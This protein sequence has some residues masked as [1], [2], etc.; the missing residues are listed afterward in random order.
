MSNKES[1]RDAGMCLGG[2]LG[3]FL[4][5]IL[6]FA[7]CAQ[8]ALEKIIRN[9][10]SV[11]PDQALLPFL[12]VLAGGCVGAAAGVLLFRFAFAAYGLVCNESVAK[13]E[14]P[15]KDDKPSA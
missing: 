11:H 12:G 1:A 14:T 7:I 9:D 4:G 13:G 15:K 10:G 3:L 2:F 5:A 6:G 8:F